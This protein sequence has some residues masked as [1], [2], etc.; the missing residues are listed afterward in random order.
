MDATVLA[1]VRMGLT[2]LTDRILT[3][4][5]LWMTF[6]L[7]CWAMYT[8]TIERLYVVAGFACLVYV[9][10]VIKERRRE[11]RKQQQEPQ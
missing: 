10:A 4:F 3:L 11:E 7:T 6:G 8:P 2:V 5:S 9:P 1:I